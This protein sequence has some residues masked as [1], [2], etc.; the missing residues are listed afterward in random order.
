MKKFSRLQVATFYTAIGSAAFT[1]ITI[2]ALIYKLA[3]VLF[4]FQA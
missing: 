4:G 1:A 3:S 2:L